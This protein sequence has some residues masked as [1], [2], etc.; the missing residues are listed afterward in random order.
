MKAVKG[1]FDGTKVLLPD[2][3]AERPGEVVVIFEDGAEGFAA[4]SD[5]VFAKV[6]D[7]AEDAAYDEL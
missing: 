5:E 6:W 1:Y 2:D 4:L 7:N 3:V